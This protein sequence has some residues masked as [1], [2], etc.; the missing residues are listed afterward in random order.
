MEDPERNVRR[1]VNRHT[2]HVL[3]VGGLGTAAGRT[4][5]TCWPFAT[6]LARPTENTT[7]YPRTL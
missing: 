6:G 3:G 7:L 1:Q 4:T 2:E 5:F